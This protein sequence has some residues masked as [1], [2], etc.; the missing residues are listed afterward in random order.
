MSLRLRIV[1]LVALVLLLSMLM[2]TLV[3]GLEARAALGAELNAGLTGAAQTVRSAFEDLPRSEHPERDLRQLTATFDGNRH[4]RA[5]LVRADGSVALASETTKGLASAPT[6]FR[7]LL[8][9]AP[10]PFQ[11]SVPADLGGYRSIALTPIAEIDAANAWSEFI[12]IVLVL[13]GSAAAGLVAVYFLI[14]AA[15]RPL[16]SLS[17][18]FARIGAGDYTGR[19]AETGPQELLGLQQGF[20]RMAG[21]LAATTSRNRQ[22]TD[23]L[24]TIQEE[25]RADIARDL[26]DEFG[27]HLFAVNMDAETIAQLNSAGRHE[28]V[29]EQVKSI[30]GAVSHMQRQVRDLLGRLRPTRL[31]EFGLKA[32]I[33]D[34]CR[35]WTARRPDIA[36][37]VR[38][39]TPEA[40]IGETITE[41]AY[42]LVQEAVNNAVRH[43]NPRAIAIGLAI[44]EDAVLVVK[45]TDDGRDASAAASHGGLGLVGMRERVA[46]AGGTLKY[47]KREDTSGWSVL[48]RI[49]LERSMSLHAEVQA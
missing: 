32:A 47:G 27:P 48:A 3:A 14:G 40:Q 24:F 35:F 28:A 7:R 2:G 19:I 37:D 30:Q 22:L 20:N 46:A 36:F 16:N 39:E 31:T 38:I 21:E 44:E 13:F 11:L 6:W 1:S 33:D 10:A 43:G 15:F 17:G 29:P 12:G 18:E 25:E 45:I 41:V 26:H 34:L 49:P 5:A 8:G 4:V 9:H 42:R 23:Q